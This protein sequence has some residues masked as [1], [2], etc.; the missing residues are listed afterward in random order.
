MIN[1]IKSCI[2][3]VCIKVVRLIST[4]IKPYA[5]PNRQ[6]EP[7]GN[8]LYNEKRLCPGKKHMPGE[9]SGSGWRRQG[10]ESRN[11][12]GSEHAC[13]LEPNVAGLNIC[14]VIFAPLLP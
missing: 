4:L 3:L 2:A 9:I 11:A 13:S 8:E 7:K 1:Q 5:L 12:L 14:L 10:R 6:V